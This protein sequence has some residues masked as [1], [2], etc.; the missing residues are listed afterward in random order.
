MKYEQFIS[1]N[2]SLFFFQT[3]SITELFDGLWRTTCCLFNACDFCYNGTWRI[4]ILCSAATVNVLFKGSTIPYVQG[5]VYYGLVYCISLP[6]GTL[7]WTLLT[8]DSEG[9][10]WDP[11]F[12]DKTAFALLGLCF[13]LPGIVM[14]YRFGTKQ[15]NQTPDSYE[16]LK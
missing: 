6:L 2:L 10:H 5:A 13:I 8:D 3:S 15:Q 1:P 16:T 14:Y 7:F 12:N 9:F 4:W 11:H